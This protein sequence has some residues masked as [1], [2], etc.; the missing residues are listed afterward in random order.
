M[1]CVGAEE[2]RTTGPQTSD[3]RAANK[4]VTGDSAE[5][6]NGAAEIVVVEQGGLGEKRTRLGKGT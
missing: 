2:T 3:V 4:E 1:G 5:V 6:V